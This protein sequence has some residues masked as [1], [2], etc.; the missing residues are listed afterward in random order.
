MLLSPLLWSALTKQDNQRST[1][2]LYLLGDFSWAEKA[3]DADKLQEFLELVVKA[4][5][6]S[7]Y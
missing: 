5:N 4:V 7:L 3:W 2:Y 6:P 1:I